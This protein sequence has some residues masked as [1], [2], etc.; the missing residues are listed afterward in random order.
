MRLWLLLIPL[1]V[2]ATDW[3]TPQAAPFVSAAACADCHGEIV[4]QW[5][6]SRHKVAWSNIIFQTEYQQKAPG[7][8]CITC[9]AP[10]AE[11]AAEA[12]YGSPGESAHEGVTCATCH[13]R[14]GQILGVSDGAAHP[15]D[16]VARDPD[17][18]CAGCHD[19]DFP[20]STE[21][22]QATVR[23]AQALGAES[24]VS[25]HMPQGEHNFKGGHDLETL[26]GAIS[27][28]ATRKRDRVEFTIEAKNVG[29]AVPTGE[30]Y[31]HL[32]LE[33]RA[34]GGWT[35]LAWLGRRLQ[36]ATEGDPSVLLT[37]L[38]T[39]LWPGQPLVV[40]TTAKADAWRLRF[41]YAPDSSPLPEETRTALVAQGAL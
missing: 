21:P 27:V 4:A 28:T 33:I 11:Q 36:R 35:E 10:L 8:F 18:L 25:C 38:D 7:P 12:L 13:V 14:A 39:R 41:H 37:I 19:F 2:V 22:M 31:R 5:S 3:P 17:A 16:G 6:A 29:H 32:T 40:S 9:H 23:E 24:C 26:R 34:R 1:A 15:Y 20:N 30:L